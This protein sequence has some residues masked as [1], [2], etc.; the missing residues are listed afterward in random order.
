MMKT[1]TQSRDAFTLIETVMSLTIGSL[2]VLLAV[3]LIHKSFHLSKAAKSRSELSVGFDRMADTLRT[4]LYSADSY[5]VA[6]DGS[7]IE[8]SIGMSRWAYQSRDGYLQRA[9]R[10]GDGF[11]TLDRV[12]LNGPAID[13]RKRELQFSVQEELVSLKLYALNQGSKIL[14]REVLIR[15]TRWLVAPQQTDGSTQPPTEVDA[16]SSESSEEAGA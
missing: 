15:P 10:K 11:R 2:I 4:D 9:E 5:Q 13:T 3:G 6:E 14:E 7:G 1:T 8:V 16:K 12:R